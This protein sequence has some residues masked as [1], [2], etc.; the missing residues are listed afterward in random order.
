MMT[1]SIITQAFW[2]ASDA[3]EW[4]GS[5]D[6]HSAWSNLVLLSSMAFTSA[7]STRPNTHWIKSRE[8]LVT[9]LILW[10]VLRRSKRISSGERLAL[11]RAFIG[12]HH[13]YNF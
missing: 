1:W 12:H 13:R 9:S 7:M 4:D 3:W 5:R 11:D 10:C 2:S 6:G 8:N